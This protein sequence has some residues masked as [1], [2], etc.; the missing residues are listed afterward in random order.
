LRPSGRRLSAWRPWH[1]VRRRALRGRALVEAHVE[2]VG[3]VEDLVV[4]KALARAGR[5]ETSADSKELLGQCRGD[6]TADEYKDRLDNYTFSEDE[7]AVGDFIWQL[8]YDLS[9]SKHVNV[10]EEFRPLLGQL[11]GVR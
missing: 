11:F 6:V 5:P 4:T 9:E 10:P 7:V 1:L 3:G 2:V 8:T